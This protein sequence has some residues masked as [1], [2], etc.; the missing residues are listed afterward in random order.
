MTVVGYLDI[1]S[2]PS[3]TRGNTLGKSLTFLNPIL[4]RYPG[5]I[6][7]DADFVCVSDVRDVGVNDVATRHQE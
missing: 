1:A 4:R 7:L 6:V 2:F 3:V 5:V